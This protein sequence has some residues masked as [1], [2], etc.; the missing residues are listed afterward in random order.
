VW[1]SASARLLERA[2]ATVFFPG[3][4]GTCD[5]LFEVLTLLQTRKI[6]PIPVVLVGEAY[7]RSLVDFQMLADEG[8]IAPGDL[9]LFRFCERAEDIWSAICEWYDAKA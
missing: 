2:K 3:G 8:M 7:W 5:E 6:E 9:S 4:F 1:R